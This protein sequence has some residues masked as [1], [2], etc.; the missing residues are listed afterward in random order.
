VRPVGHEVR[1]PAAAIRCG[2]G[3][4][5]GHGF[6]QRHL[7]GSFKKRFLELF[8]GTCHL[9]S[10]FASAGYQAES[11]EIARS[12]KEDILSPS[13]STALFARLRSGAFAA[14]WLGLTCGSWTLARRGK[15]DYSGWPPP[16]RSKE[17][18][19]GLPGL[20]AADE[21]RVQAGNATAIWA[22]KFF[23]EAA[24][25]GVP[26][27]LENP[28]SSRLWSCPPI[29]A[30]L[31]RYGS[32]LVHQCQHGTPWKKATRLL[33]AN[34]NLTNTAKKCSG[35]LCSRTGLPHA[36]LSGVAKGNFLTAAASPYPKALCRSVVDSFEA[37]QKEQLLD[38][39][40]DLIL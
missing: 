5:A 10:A 29:L 38:K 7:V 6:G 4:R 3:A 9:S 26:V 33:R 28:A 31:E 20:S 30:L 14:V 21:R 17:R 13:N 11:W 27:A 34:W 40:S 16:L 32:E 39:L 18:I 8:A 19:W 23:A 15:P 37:Q 36:I 24:R 35:K 25:R 22:A 2:S 12:T 1:D